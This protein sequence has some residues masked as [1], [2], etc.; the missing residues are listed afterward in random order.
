MEKQQLKRMDE[1]AIY[2]LAEDGDYSDDEIDEWA[3]QR[4]IK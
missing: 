2:A 4:G 3:K 1:I